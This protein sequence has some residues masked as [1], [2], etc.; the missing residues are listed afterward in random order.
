MS[1]D[2]LEVSILEM[3]LRDND[4]SW[5]DEVHCEQ[6]AE[7][8]IGRRE[9]DEILRLDAF[10]RASR[11]CN[12]TSS[13][14]PLHH[15]PLHDYRTVIQYMCPRIVIPGEQALQERWLH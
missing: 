7:D 4:F 12:S 1:D 15:S 10:C 5:L 8:A 9:A 6:L 2:S 11:A 3:W 14:A 13:D